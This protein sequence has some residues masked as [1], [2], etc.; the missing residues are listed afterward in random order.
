MCVHAGLDRRRKGTPAPG[1]NQLAGTGAWGQATLS[2]TVN[3]CLSSLG[4]SSELITEGDSYLG[5]HCGEIVQMVLS[6]P[7]LSSLQ[8][9]VLSHSSVPL[10]GD[11]TSLTE[12]SVFAKRS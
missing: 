6:S 9:C 10:Q 12:T 4:L 2:N 7:G 1:I 8:A 3:R 11:K 5:G